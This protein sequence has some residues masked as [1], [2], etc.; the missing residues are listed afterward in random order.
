MP[1]TK[2]TRN[3]A[4]L[5]PV[6]SSEVT[7]GS[8]TSA[9]IADGAVTE[10]KISA[11]S[12]TTS[13]LGE[14]S[15]TETKIG[16][17]AVSSGKLAADSV[18]TAKI[19]DA[20]VTAAKL[21]TDSVTTAKIAA[22]AVT[23]A[24]IAD[25][26]VTTAKIAASAVT[27]AKLADNS[28]TTAKIAA[29]A[30]TLA[31]LASGINSGIAKAWINF[32][33]ASAAILTGRKSLNVTSVTDNGLGDYTIN[34][35]AGAVTDVNYAAVATCNMSG[36]NACVPLMFANSSISAVAPTVNAFRMVTISRAAGSLLDCS[37]VNVAV[38]N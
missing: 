37:Y 32:D 26:G 28:V 24:K 7:D 9:K 17:L 35:S 36:P 33:G 38:F 25:L 27:D 6:A 4:N 3:V 22:L 5:F 14:G 30:V 13:K 31:K 16:S 15:V 20:N 29:N 1:L 19:L 18:I 10:G 12:V 23:D 11:G 34:L 8:I 21:A 2:V